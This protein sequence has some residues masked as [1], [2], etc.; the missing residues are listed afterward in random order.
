M[1]IVNYFKNRYTNN[2]LDTVA[3]RINEDNSSP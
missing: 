1:K 2:L 3:K